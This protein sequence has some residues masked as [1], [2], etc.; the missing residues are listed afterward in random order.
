MSNMTL[1][2]HN[3]WGSA[4]DGLARSQTR[5]TKLLSLPLRT[6]ACLGDHS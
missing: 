1:A 3:R 6:E 2:L 5:R 4:W